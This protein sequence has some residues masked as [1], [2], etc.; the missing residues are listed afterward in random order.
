MLEDG[1]I[2]C[3]TILSEEMRRAEAGSWRFDTCEGYKWSR[4]VWESDEC[5]LPIR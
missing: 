2:L 1:F 4:N 3:R 5:R